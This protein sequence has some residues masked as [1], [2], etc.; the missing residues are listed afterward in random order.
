M[1]D[2]SQAKEDAQHKSAQHCNIAFLITSR[3]DSSIFTTIISVPISPILMDPHKYFQVLFSHT[4]RLDL[5]TE[6]S[7]VSL[8]KDNKM[9]LFIKL[10]T[11]EAF[12]PFSELCETRMQ[13]HL[14]YV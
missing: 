12:P 2:V 10:V 11:F 1:K 14:T 13:L 5:G 7:W 4:L 3:C 9:E 6:T 8:V